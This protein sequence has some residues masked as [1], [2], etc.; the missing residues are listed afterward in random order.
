VPLMRHFQTAASVLT[1][2]LPISKNLKI[3]LMEENMKLCMN[4]ML[5]ALSY[6]LDSVEGELLGVSTHHA[7]RVAY[8]CVTMGREL[9]YDAGKL[10][11]LAGAAVMHD[12]ALT[13]YVAAR[14]S[15]GFMDNVL[16][17]D[18]KP[19]CELG[20]K[21][22]HS[23]PFYED[24]TDVVLYHHENA[25]GSGPFGKKTDETPLFSRL[26]HIADQADNAFHLDALTPGKYDELLEWMQLYKGRMFDP[27]LVSL[28]GS[29]F[30]YDVLE[31]ASGQ[32][33]VTQLPAA[34]P[35]YESDYSNE[36]V[37]DFATLFARITDYKSHFTSVHSQGCAWKARR[38]GEYYGYDS[39]VCTK[40]YLA[41]A[42][43]DIGKLTISNDILEKPDKL[44]PEEFAI[45]KTHAQ[46]S[47]NILRDLKDIPDIVAWACMHHEKLDGSGYPFGKK[48]AELD[49]NER[50]MA[51]ID[52]YQ[53]LTELRPYRA[54]LPH[55]KAICI[56]RGMA[57]D[58]KIDPDITEDIDQCMR[59]PV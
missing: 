37:L 31:K 26:I 1:H 57:A 52:I 47:W 27:E 5:Y 17:T 14:R 9:G 2:R 41:G 29:V 23:L 48:A 43:H 19:H 12:N 49:K 35:V 13:E 50:L 18:L 3:L 28:F 58:E 30:R 42:L 25:D 4:G 39:T 33:I 20:E 32:N 6:A 44:T 59:S 56:M 53:A 11:A 7:E 40:L 36:T 54:V 22:M 51:C 16:T 8:M 10:S 34:L 46:A 15:G 55:E 45:M 21:N 38:M 24:V